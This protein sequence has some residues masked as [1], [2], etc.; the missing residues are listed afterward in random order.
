MNEQHSIT[1][2]VHHIGEVE[3]FKGDFTKRVLVL[4]TE[5]KYNNTV[6]IYFKKERTVEL[7]R[8][9]LGELVKVFYD[10]GGRK[11]DDRYYPDIT[12]WRFEK[13]EEK[14]P[15]PEP[16]QKSEQPHHSEVDEGEGDSIPF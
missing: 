9:S 7:D 16:A 2:R 10:L 8:L 14:A 5:E 11:H 1:G 15:A 13:L 4:E 12:G 6:P 3:T